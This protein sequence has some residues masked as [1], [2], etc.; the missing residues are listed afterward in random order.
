M[1]MMMMRMMMMMMLMMMAMM[2]MMLVMMTNLLM[3][4]MMMMLMMVLIYKTHRAITLPWLAKDLNIPDNTDAE[5]P[6]LYIEIV[7]YK[8]R[9]LHP[10]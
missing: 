10:A 7:T 4:V 9:R 8:G 1:M 6:V 5:E 2:V 3:M